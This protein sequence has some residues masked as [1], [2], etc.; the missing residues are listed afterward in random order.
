[1]NKIYKL[2]CEENWEELLQLD[3]LN[4]ELAAGRVLQ[5]FTALQ[6]NFPPTFKRLRKA[7]IMQIP[8]D[9]NHSWDI[10]YHD[11]LP[12][13]VSLDN[14]E[15]DEQADNAVTKFYDKKRLPSYCD[16]I[17]F[18]SWECYEGNLNCEFFE[19]CELVTSSDHKPVRASF[20]L[21][22][23][24]GLKEINV[25]CEEKKS[26]GFHL[27][28]FG[29]MNDRGSFHGQSIIQNHTDLFGLGSNHGSE[30]G[31]ALSTKYSNST[32]TNLSS[33]DR[34]YAEIDADIES[35]HAR[36]ISKMRFEFYN[37]S[38]VNL[39]EMDSKLAGGLSDP[40]ITIH[41]DPVSLG[42]NPK[43]DKSASMFSIQICDCMLYST[44]PHEVVSSVIS[45]NINPTW[46][47]H[48][49][50][51]V[52]SYDVPG[53]EENFNFV[54]SVWDHDR[55]NEDDLIGTCIVSMKEMISSLTTIELDKRRYRFEKDL[56]SQG[57]LFLSVLF[58]RS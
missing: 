41:T 43:Y 21:E 27:P 13:K 10:S 11:M 7:S 25:F 5:G 35:N 48:L 4:R 34:T 38:G 44:K 2:I 49:S 36:V 16:R 8:S 31:S 1:M 14:V 3:E 46:E 37:M 42:Y 20:T 33:T 45:H 50:M 47:D 23:C 54:I 57:K 40:Y 6:P 32:I 58:I 30:R 28:M 39:A 51:N 18:K 56:I 17:L 52:L 9:E 26:G 53:M 22:T 19:S 12:S 24:G 15:N 55:F 29:H